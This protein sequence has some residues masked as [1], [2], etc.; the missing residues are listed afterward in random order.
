MAKVTSVL[1][2]AESALEF[3]FGISAPTEMKICVD[4]KQ[5]FVAF[6]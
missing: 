6:Y 2:M 3:S 5:T 1:I 4:Q